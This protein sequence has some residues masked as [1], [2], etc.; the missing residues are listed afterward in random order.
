MII[1]KQQIP[2]KSDQASQLSGLKALE[3]TQLNILILSKEH[4]LIE[5]LKYFFEKHISENNNIRI[6]SCPDICKSDLNIIKCKHCYAITALKEIENSSTNDIILPDILLI[7]DNGFLETSV[8]GRT[9]N[10]ENEFISSLEKYFKKDYSGINY[11]GN[12][13]KIIILT[14]NN[15]VL[16]LKQLVET[17]LKGLIHRTS[18]MHE[19]LEAIE[20]VKSGAFYI[21]RQINY[22]IYEYHK[23]L[24]DHPINKLT[25]RQIE[26]LYEISNNLRNHQIAPKLNISVG[27]VEKHKSNIESILNLN[28]DEIISFAV[29]NK[30]EIQY[31]L[32]F[33][34]RRDWK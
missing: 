19:I 30:N 5:G 25:N 29:N 33:S 21:D 20:T 9:P 22:L 6:S 3:G 28:S 11:N 14:G 32:K 15:N 10:S 2:L 1:K 4:F 12:E 34:K 18:T 17:G 26:I 23:Y 7:D 31:L 24:S 8:A 16:Y 13:F 27:A